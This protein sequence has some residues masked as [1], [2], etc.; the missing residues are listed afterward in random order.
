MSSIF[1]FSTESSG[2]GDFIPVVKFDSRSGRAFRVDREND[3]SGW[4][5]T[6]VDITKNFKCVMDLENLETGWVHFPAGSAP[7]FSMVPLGEPLPPKPTPDAKNG[8][9]VM[10]KL[11]SAVGGDKPIREIAG[12]AKAFLAGIESLY[13][14]YKEQA[15]ANPGKLP[16]VVLE[17]TVPITSGSGDKKSTNYS[18]V[19]KITGWA[20][21][22]DLV[23]QPKNGGTG[24]PTLAAAAAAVASDA[25]QAP[26]ST[27]STRVEAPKA[28]AP[29]PAMADDDSDFG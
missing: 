3:G 4:V 19:F 6:Q 5:T 18:P 25:R 26:P 7:I 28:K 2:G 24:V 20:P 13:I 14:A 12:N 27:G 10:L 29:E 15:P 16:I 11:S 21:R 9:R 17:D 8:V 23:F 1:G 22:G